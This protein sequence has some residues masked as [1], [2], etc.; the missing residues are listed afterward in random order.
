MTLS[1]QLLFLKANPAIGGTGMVRGNMLAW[2][3]PVQPTPLARSYQANIA[4]LLGKAPTVRISEPDLQILAQGRTLPHVYNNPLR[5]CLHLPGDEGWDPTKRIDQTII[6]WTYMWLFYFEDWLA[7]DDWKGGGQ[8]PG[9]EPE[10]PGNR[11][12]RRAISRS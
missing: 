4:Y 1:Q 11:A 9:A 10:D 3:T 8:H 5:L 7:T 12:L 6:P 2:Q